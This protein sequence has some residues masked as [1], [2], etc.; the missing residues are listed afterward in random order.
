MLFVARGGPDFSKTAHNKCY[1]ECYKAHYV[2][3]KVWAGVH[4]GKAVHN[5]R[6][7]CRRNKQNSVKSGQEDTS[8]SMHTSKCSM[9]YC[10]TL[11][12]LCSYAIAPSDISATSARATSSFLRLVL[13][14]NCTRVADPVSNLRKIAPR[15]W[16]LEPSNLL[17]L[18]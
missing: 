12:R 3:S 11:K 10:A 5:Q 8:A 7:I 15:S 4:G 16:R 6:N 13:F 14:I 18:V 2:R 9:L 17:C 1:R